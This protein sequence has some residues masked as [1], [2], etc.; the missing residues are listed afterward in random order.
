MR[1]AGGIQPVFSPAGL[2]PA[3]ESGGIGRRAGFRIVLPHHL[4]LP[5]LISAKKINHRVSLDSGQFNCVRHKSGTIKLS[6]LSLIH[7][8]IRYKD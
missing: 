4:S 7:L 8:L 1:L 5:Q 6:F 3:R 2:V